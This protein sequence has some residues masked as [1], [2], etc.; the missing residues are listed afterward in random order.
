MG[1]VG[2]AAIGRAPLWP[3]AMLPAPQAR[4]RGAPVRHAAVPRRGG[5]EGVGQALLVSQG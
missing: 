1:R 3:E 4:S 2:R 5:A